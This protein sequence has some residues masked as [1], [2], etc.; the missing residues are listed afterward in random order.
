MM[1]STRFQ[2]TETRPD[3]SAMISTALANEPLKL[4]YA[5]L[6]AIKEAA[7]VSNYI[8]SSLFS[9]RAVKIAKITTLEIGIARFEYCCFAS[10]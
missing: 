8:F 9:K 6:K 3:T 5:V 7:L 10:V 4:A 1:G 2:R